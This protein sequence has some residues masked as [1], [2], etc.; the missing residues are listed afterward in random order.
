[1]NTA[2][3]K[4]FTLTGLLI[5]VHLV[6]L[7]TSKASIIYISG[8]STM[9]S[10]VYSTLTTAGVVYPS[11]PSFTG[12]DGNFASNCNYM[13][14]KGTI[15]AG[16]VVIKCSWTGSEAGIRDIADHSDFSEPFLLDTAP[17]GFHSEQPDNVEYQKV[18][19]ATA[20]N[21]Q[22]YS[23][24]PSPAITA[25]QEVAVVPFVW[26][27]NPGLWTGNNVTDPMIRQALG[28]FCKRAVFSGN[29]AHI[30]DYVFVSGRNNLSGARVN[31]FGFSGF[32]IFTSPNQIEMDASGNMLDLD[33]PNG[34]YA[35]DFG[36]TSGG[37]LAAT[38]GADTTA[39]ADLFNGGTGYSVIA[40][41]GRV[42]A[43]TAIANGGVELNYNGASE[44]SQAVIEGRYAFWGNEYVYLYE[45]PNLGAEAIYNELVA[46][47]GLPAFCDGRAAIKLSDM[48]CTRTGPLN[49]PVHN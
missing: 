21:L 38:M 41:L 26:V 39:K 46:S 47:T 8:S 31:G 4:H 5:S 7:S 33:P 18:D 35:G 25:Y 24:N 34:V 32:G 16:Q 13:T 49:D 27:R 10:I 22:A 42:D 29:S 19:I 12:Y 11:A 17:A 1:M 6:G 30:S 37:T 3:F 43:D 28:G 20:D 36:F 14:F 40:Y 45:N 48:H 15:G 2:N 44:S 23:R 9:R